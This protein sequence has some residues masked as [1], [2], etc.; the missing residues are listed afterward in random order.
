MRPFSLLSVIFSLI[1]ILSISAQAAAQS[2][3]R[4]QIQAEIKSLRDRLKSREQELLS[5]TP[6][7]RAA[8]AEFLAAPD[9][10]I[11]R[12][13]P[14]PKT[15][16]ESKVSVRGGG[17]YYSFALSTHEYGRGS[18]IE[19]QQGYFLVGFAGADYGFFAALGDVPLESVSLDSPGVAFLSS[20]ETPSEL[21][22]ARAQQARSDEGIER[23][24]VTYKNRV[25]ASVGQTYILR[26]INYDDSDVLV[27]FRVIRKDDDGS[28]ILLWN[29]LRKL[30]PP[31]LVRDRN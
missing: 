10:G 4:A 5:P 31:A 9:T 21:T 7:D 12:L 17:A 20:L 29:M 28:L 2:T 16:A 3:D 11:I 18:D 1:S 13:L 24:G 23:E 14:R 26:S 22:G 15:E 6:A 19:L 8:F 27:G 30:A 25:A